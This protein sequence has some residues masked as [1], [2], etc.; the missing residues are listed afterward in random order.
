M[1]TLKVD[2]ILKRTGTGTITVGQSGDTISIP[3]GA[4]LTVAGS[5]ITAASNTPSFSVR[6]AS[7]QTG[8]NTNSATKITFDTEDVDTDNAFASSKFTVPSGKAGKYFLTSSLTVQTSTGVTNLRLL[9]LQ[10][11]KNGGQYDST[12][13]QND[14]RN[15]YTYVGTVSASLI[16]DLAVSDYIEIYVR[17]LDEADGNN[18]IAKGK[19]CVFAGYK[20]LWG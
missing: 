13:F 14:Y 16:L 8:I 15:N 3:S 17:V 10:F 4:S 12:Q 18:S 6:N 11:Y 19:K 9:S 7:D 5:T 20:L 1:S 2:T